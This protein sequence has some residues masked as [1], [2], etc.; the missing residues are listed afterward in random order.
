MESMKN[1][2]N[3]GREILLIGGAGYIGSA[4]TGQLLGAGHKVRCLDLL[5]YHNAQSIFPYLNDPNYRFQHGDLTDAFAAQSAL[6]GVTDVVILAGLVG[7]PITKKYPDASMRIN[8]L[9]MRQ[10][11]SSL[12]GH[13]LERVIFISTCSNYGLIPEN[14]L[15][16]EQ[17]ELS[18]L[19][20]LRQGQSRDGAGASLA[21][22]Q[23]RLFGDHPEVCDRFR[24]FSADAI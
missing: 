23:S 8:E 22:R 5:L 11:I 2:Q 9:G 16:D 15:A 4:L 10:F 18:P 19:F 20:A 13:G 14:V 1:R 21:Q 3:S 6:K 17:F 12:N 7:D 24:S